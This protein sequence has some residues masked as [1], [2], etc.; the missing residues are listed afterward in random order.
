VS[1]RRPPPAE[2][3]LVALLAAAVVLVLVELALGAAG[4]VPP[5]IANP[6]RPRP[7]HGGGLDAAVQRIVLDGLDGA[8]CRLH[9]T[10]EELVLSLGSGT[11]FRRRWDRRTIEV[12]L[13]AGLLRS[14]DEAER[15]GD[16][17]GF[18]APAV[19]RVV[20]RAPLDRLVRGAIRLRDLLG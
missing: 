15:R 3:A 1:D 10:R 5:T 20:E 2:I 7:A 16:L 17:P 9:T 8:A 13:R 4:H 6:C 12:A 18:L 14:V 19:R 11:G